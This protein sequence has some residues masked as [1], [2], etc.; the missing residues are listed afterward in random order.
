MGRHGHVRAVLTV[1]ACAVALAACGGGGAPRAPKH[2]FAYDASRPLLGE[3]HGVVIR[4]PVA[5]HIVSYAADDGSR[6]PALL[7]VPRSGRVAGCLMYQPGA[8]LPKEA[9]APLWPGGAKLGLAIFS[10][11]LRLTGARAGGLI[12]LTQAF[13]DPNL[14]VKY[15]RLDVIDLRRGIDYLEAQ[16]VC[17]H[18]IGYF[19][20]SNGAGLGVQL[21]GSDSRIRATVLAS[22]GATIR[23]R[24]FYSPVFLAGLY[25]HP[26]AFKAALSLLA[27]YNQDRWIAKI[28]PR[29]VMIVDGLRDPNVPP[30]DALDLAAAA[31][32]PK[33]LVFDPGGHDPFAGPQAANV[34]KQIGTFLL[35]NL[36][37]HSSG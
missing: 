30:I 20:W 14:I 9:A 35:Q 25:K 1:F 23:A 11:D 28:S 26:A 32:Q 21:S 24:L 3:T 17:H 7:A 15:T 4:G 29:P 8:Y 34:A 16:P 33:Q 27:P 22:L 10:I 2:P 37:H 36:V 12:T 6:V 31:G 19:G 5:V 18:N 13:N